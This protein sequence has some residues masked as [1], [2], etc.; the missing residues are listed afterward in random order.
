MK[1]QDLLGFIEVGFIL[2]I[3]YHM[4]EFNDKG[5]IKSHDIEAY[6]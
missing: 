2:I 6:A 3:A 1:K 4:F 5:E